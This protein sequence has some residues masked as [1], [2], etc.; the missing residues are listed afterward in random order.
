MFLLIQT[1]RQLAL[2]SVKKCRRGMPAVVLLLHLLLLKSKLWK[3]VEK[4]RERRSLGKQDAGGDLML[5]F[6]H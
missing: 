4:K 5:T 6:Q 1:T 2:W 3:R